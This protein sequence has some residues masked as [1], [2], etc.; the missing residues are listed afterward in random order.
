MNHIFPFSAFVGQEMMLTG[1]LLN[2]INP[3]IGGILIRGEKGTGKSTVVRALASLL[4]EISVVEGCPFGCSPD[5]DPALCPHCSRAAAEGPL[6]TVSRQTRVVDLPIN[7]TEDR[8]AGT[9]DLEHALQTGEKR[10]EPGLLAR[11]NR[12]I[13]YVDE[14]NL[15]EDHIVDILLDSAAMG[16]NKVEREG[17]S[18]TH[19]ARFILVGTMNPEEGDL[20]PQLLDRFGLCVTVKGIGDLGKR[21]E[22]LRRWEAFEED[23]E[24]F[25]ARFCKEETR[26]KKRIAKA[27]ETLPKV[28]ADDG[29][30]RAITDLA[31]RMGVDGHRADLVILKTAK[32]HAAFDARRTVT[33]EDVS[34]AAKFALYHRMRRQPFDDLP[35]DMA[36]VDKLLSQPEHCEQN[37][38]KVLTQ[39]PAGPGDEGRRE[40]APFR[41]A[42]PESDAKIGKLSESRVAGLVLDAG[43]CGRI[44]DEPEKRKRHRRP[45]CENGRGR[46]AKVEHRTG[47]YIRTSCTATGTDIALDATLRAAAPYASQRPRGLLALPIL[48]EDWRTKIRTNRVGSLIVFVVDASGSMGSFLMHQTKAA[49]LHLLDRAYKDRSEAALVA[50]KARGAELL[51]PPTRNIVNAEKKLRNLPTGGTTPLSAG[52]FLG[53]RVA[54][55]AL[56]MGRIQSPHIVL[57]TDGRANVGLDP[58]RFSMGLPALPL[59]EEVFAV[60]RNVRKDG[61]IRSLVIDTEDKK[62][63]NLDMARQI[64]SHMGARYVAMGTLRP[65]RIVEAVMA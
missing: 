50:F 9:L 7:A 42:G 11:A 31:V 43:D 16:V 14:V 19:P 57:V 44:E 1:L 54:Q 56:S 46:T 13:L 28:K 62:P 33:L 64:A 30:I 37:K 58:A 60:A 12:G 8:V 6:A 3:R 4:P 34:L 15:L 49:I 51:L 26:L 47:R 55:K 59:H 39:D 45:R 36:M 18:F 29:I 41:K 17:V 20:R 5:S 23:P 63:G 65:E 2:A 53:H 52:L 10:F 61:R 40:E 21:D 48:R 32:T 38:K 22:L 35:E 25:Q 27:R 24:A